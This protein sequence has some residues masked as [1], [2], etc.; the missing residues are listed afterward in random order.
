MSADAP[1]RRPSTKRCTDVAILLLQIG[2]RDGEAVGEAGGETF[3]LLEPGE[4]E[5]LVRAAA[6]VDA[7]GQRLERTRRRQ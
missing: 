6:A 2:A 1:F 5:L 7:Y 3:R 4:A